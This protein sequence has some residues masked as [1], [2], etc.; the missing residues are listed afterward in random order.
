ML[1]WNPQK[2]PNAAQSLRYPYF[3]VGVD[4]PQN[5]PNPKPASGIQIDDIRRM[6]EAG[7]PV[8]PIPKKANALSENYDFDAESNRQR[9]MNDGSIRRITDSGEP[10]N[11]VQKKTSSIFDDFDLDMIKDDIRSKKTV[12]TKRQSDKDRS[13]PI[14]N[15]ESDS[16]LDYGVKNFS[17]SRRDSSKRISGLADDEDVKKVIKPKDSKLSFLENVP[18]NSNKQNN[19]KGNHEPTISNRNF[20][21]ENF[22]SNIDSNSLTKATQQNGSTVFGNERRKWQ[23][24]SK[25]SSNENVFDD[26]MD[27]IVNTNYKTPSKVGKFC[28]YID[29]QLKHV[30]D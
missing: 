12:A 8:K 18:R 10:V 30:P 4:L 24:S 21:R 28:L 2:R 7:K 5:K 23:T 20:G 6:S 3:M 22:H 17:K 13:I 11:A 9:P 1:L 16:F 19:L 27:D 14:K 29:V 15:V 26:F 25:W